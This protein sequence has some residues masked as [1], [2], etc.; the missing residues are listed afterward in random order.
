LGEDRKTKNSYGIGEQTLSNMGI[1]IISVV[2][3]AAT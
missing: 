3:D 1:Q 2:K